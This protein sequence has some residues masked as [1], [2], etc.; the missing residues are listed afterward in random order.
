MD[1]TG[2]QLVRGRRRECSTET[3]VVYGTYV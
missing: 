1:A 2:I 3:Y